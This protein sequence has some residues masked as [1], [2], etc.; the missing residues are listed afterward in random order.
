[1]IIATEE[2]FPPP[3]VEMLNA[4]VEE[5]VAVDVTTELWPGSRES[6]RIRLEG[7]AEEIKEW[8]SALIAGIESNHQHPLLRAAPRQAAICFR[9][10]CP[11]L[12]PYGRGDDPL[13]TCQLCGEGENSGFH[14]L[15]SCKCHK[16]FEIRHGLLPPEIIAEWKDCRNEGEFAQL[17]EFL[18]EKEPWLNNESERTRDLL[19]INNGG[20]DLDVLARLVTH[21]LRDKDEN[22]VLRKQN[23]ISRSGEVVRHKLKSKSSSY[24]RHRE[25]K[26]DL[27]TA[28]AWVGNIVTDLWKVYCARSKGRQR[29]GEDDLI[30]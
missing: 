16:A 9:F 17:N 20:N 21:H 24:S 26:E 3:Y 14:L 10:I 15:T 22:G 12:K 28:Y 4:S 27:Y 5:V 29:G 13:D 1:M 7:S 25:L 2:T 11:S 6:W 23:L 19:L 18:L 8:H 30:A